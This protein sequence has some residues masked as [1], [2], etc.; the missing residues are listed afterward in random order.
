MVKL[1]V[2]GKLVEID[3]NE[4][5]RRFSPN[6]LGGLDQFQIMKALAERP[7]QVPA[8][9]K[10]LNLSESRDSDRDYGR[11][12]YYLIKLYEKGIVGKHKVNAKTVLWYL[13]EK[14]LEALEKGGV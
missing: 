7:K 6:A 14:G 11:V 1:V 10:D 13:T 2:K 4:L 9:M 12:R 5:E 8:I 3:E